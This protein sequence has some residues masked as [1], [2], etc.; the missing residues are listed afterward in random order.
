MKITICLQSIPPFRHS[1]QRQYWLLFSSR[2]PRSWAGQNYNTKENGLERT[3]IICLLY[4]IA[5]S[6]PAK[7]ALLCRCHTL[8]WWSSPFL[9]ETLGISREFF[10]KKNKKSICTVV[11]I[12]DWPRFCQRFNKLLFSE[13]SAQKSAG[14]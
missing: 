1:F 14:V 8:L 5:P 11:S 10:G 13:T 9:C 7:S 2:S 3:L 6:S 4:W 12:P